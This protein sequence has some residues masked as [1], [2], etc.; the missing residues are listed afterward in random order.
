MAWVIVSTGIFTSFIFEPAFDLVNAARD[1][2]TALGSWDNEVTTTTP[3]DI[4]K[5][6]AEIAIMHSEINGVVFTAGDTVSMK[7]IADIVDG[8]LKTKVK[9][10]LKPVPQLKEELAADPSNGWRKYVRPSTSLFQLCRH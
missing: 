1:N 2:V 4:G 7:Q 9:R 8:V 10:T 6:T 5:V 3:E